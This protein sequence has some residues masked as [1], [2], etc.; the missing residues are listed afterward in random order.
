MVTFQ[1]PVD[2]VLPDMLDDHGTIE[3]IV[4]FRGLAENREDGQTLPTLC[5]CGG[6]VDT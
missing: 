1:T 6:T 3:Y 2:G 5:C 4:C